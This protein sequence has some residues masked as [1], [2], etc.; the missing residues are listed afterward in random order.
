MSGQNLEEL[1]E[2]KP[3][4]ELR[5][6]ERRYR[7]DAGKLIEKADRCLAI[8]VGRDAASALQQAESGRRQYQKMKAAMQVSLMEKLSFAQEALLLVA[9]RSAEDGEE[10]RIPDFRTELRLRENT[11]G[12]W[13]A[14]DKI[15]RVYLRDQPRSN[16]GDRLVT[17]CKS[18][19]P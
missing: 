17:G 11:D 9:M 16:H 14:V 1:V 10:L 12:T 2:L 7:A 6:L 4:E 5:S 15:G 3:N 8:R 13:M 18:P 19:S